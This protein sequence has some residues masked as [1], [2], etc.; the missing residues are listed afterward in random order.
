M[1]I[2][3][4]KLRYIGDTLTLLA[5]VRAI[6]ET[7]AESRVSLMV[8]KGTE[9]I[10]AYQKEIDEL[11][12]LDRK[13]I[14][15]E[16]IWKRWQNNWKVWFKV[17]QKRFDVVIDLTSSDR[18]GIISFAS[19]SKLRVGAPLG[20]FLERF[21]YHFTIDADPQKN[22]IIDYQLASLKKLGIEV[23]EP[24]TTI[25]VPYGIEEKMRDRLLLP[26]DSKPL[27]V[28]HPGARN[29]LRRWRQER[30]GAIADRLINAYN[31][32][33]ILLGGPDEENIV[34]GVQT[35]MARKPELQL[36][37]LPLIEV[38]ALLKQARLFIGNDTATGH[39]AA[40]VGTSHII[41]FGPT[42][43]HLWAPR[44][45]RGISIFK[46]PECC[47]CRQI[48][49]LRKENPCMDWITVQDVWEA[50]GKFL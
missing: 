23:R 39:I 44:G 8:Y 49:C 25:S 2:L 38:A 7:Q 21:A 41:L 50:V 19:R 6:K 28:I 26:V 34:N 18:S 17:F 12:L 47:G 1:K 16:S 5:L 3:I 20:N 11:I 37:S 40:G 10:L 27:V 43:P 15:K 31:A 42:F 35:N 48:L 14:K 29:P 46:S 24:D 45:A 32:R 36:I 30:F 9:G 4:I 22:H 13:E 33:I